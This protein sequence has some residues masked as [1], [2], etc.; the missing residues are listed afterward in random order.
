[1]PVLERLDGIRAAAYE[2]GDVA[3]LAEVWAPGARLRR[4]ADQLR[5]LLASGATARGVRHRFGVLTLL[6]ESDRRVRLRVGQWLP[7]AVLLRGG[8]VVGRL[9]AGRPADVLVELVRV[10]GGW[11]LS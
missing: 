5:E 2:R 8:R 10:P 4:D 7:P 11:R 9:A 3:M 6:S 1:L